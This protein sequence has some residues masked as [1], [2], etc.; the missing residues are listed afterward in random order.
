MSN[1]NTSL[2]ARIKRRNKQGFS[3]LGTGK[4]I[5]NGEVRCSTS[6]R[7][8]QM[9]DYTDPKQNH[10][11]VDYKIAKSRKDRVGMKSIVNLYGVRL[12]LHKRALNKKYAD[13]HQKATK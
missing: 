10:K 2:S 7:A 8:S 11:D 4:M 13:N 3:G 1:K 6:L 12:T 5:I 9:G